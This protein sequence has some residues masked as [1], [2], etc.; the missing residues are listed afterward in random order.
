[1]RTCS[2]CGEAKPNSAFTYT[3]QYAAHCRD[4]G[5]WLYLLRQVFGPTR[6][7]MKNRERTRERE[8][9]RSLF[10]KLPAVKH[11]DTLPP[12]YE[13]WGVRKPE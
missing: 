5:V 1:M 13:A 8:Q 9:I 4:C 7:V 11:N 6:D 10:G 3:R 2:C 12:L